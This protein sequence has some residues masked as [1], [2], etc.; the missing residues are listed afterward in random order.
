MAAR[1]C[2]VSGRAPRFARAGG[3]AAAAVGLVRS[4]SPIVLFRPSIG[5]FWVADAQASTPS[6]GKLGDKLENCVMK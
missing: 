2:V 5:A 6:D 1:V 4:R 3:T